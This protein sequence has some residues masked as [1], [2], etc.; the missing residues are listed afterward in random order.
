[1]YSVHHHHWVN[2]K[3]VHQAYGNWGCE[4]NEENLKKSLCGET[5]SLKLD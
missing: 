2:E 4:S 5:P 1:M 3:T